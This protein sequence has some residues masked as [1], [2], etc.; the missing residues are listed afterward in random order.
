MLIFLNI[1]LLMFLTDIMKAFPGNRDI[2][3]LVIF[4]GVIGT[5]ICVVSI[6]KLNKK[7]GDDAN[8]C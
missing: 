7:T 6:Y 4:G 8:D 2:A 5:S 1:V 3:F